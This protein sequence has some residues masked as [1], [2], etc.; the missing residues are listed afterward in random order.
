MFYIQQKF[1]ASLQC[2]WQSH[3]I[4]MASS[5]SFHYFTTL[6][7]DLLHRA[8]H[9]LTK[10]LLH[11]RCR[12]CANIQARV[13]GFGQLIWSQNLWH[14]M[15]RYTGQEADE[16]IVEKLQACWSA[17]EAKGLLHMPHNCNHEHMTYVYNQIERSSNTHTNANKTT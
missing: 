1:L 14:E 9:L 13:V 7:F 8:F 6:T 16:V 3:T 5:Y 10:M 12:L 4:I 15:P 11:A 2:N 17:P